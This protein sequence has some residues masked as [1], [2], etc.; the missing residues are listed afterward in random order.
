MYYILCA[1]TLTRVRVG[2]GGSGGSNGGSMEDQWTGYRL[3]KIW[4]V[5]KNDRQNIWCLYF[6]LSIISEVLCVLGHCKLAPKKF[7][8]ISSSSGNSVTF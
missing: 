5:T 1:S 7:K 8:E 2:G 3:R 4:C 6:H